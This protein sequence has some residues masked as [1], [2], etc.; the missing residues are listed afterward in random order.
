MQY[1]N[2]VG[3]NINLNILQINKNAFKIPMYYF[4][5]VSLNYSSSKT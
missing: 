2:N 4:Y 3:I 5:I 1:V